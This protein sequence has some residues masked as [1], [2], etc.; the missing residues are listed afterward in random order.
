[1]G[2]LGLFCAGALLLCAACQ[3]GQAP[4]A[5]YGLA[6]EVVCRVNTEAISKGQVEER[7]PEIMDKLLAWR[8]A[9]EAAGEWN[10]EAQKK[11]DDL[12]IPPFRDALRRVVRDRMLLQHAK[13]DP[14]FRLEERIVEKRLNETMARLKSQGLVGAQG[15]SRGEVEKRV[16]EQV[17]IDTYR[18]S[19]F[20]SFVDDPRKPDVEKYYRENT[21]R[22]QRPAGVKVRIVR[23]DMR[24]PN[25][26][27]GKTEPQDARA[28]AQRLRDDV[29]LY[30]ANFIEVARNS[31]NDEESRARGG[32]I[33]LNPTDPYLNPE[34]YNQELARAIRGLQPGK[35][36]EVFALGASSFAFVLVEDRREAGPIPLE[37]ELFEQI[38]NTLREQKTRKQEDEWFR[39]ALAKS[40]VLH[41]VEGVA[42]P[43][44]V[45]FFFE[46]DEAPTE[47]P[48]EKAE[49][50][51]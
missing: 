1:V 10:A 7:M 13:A 31:S 20:S 17:T 40:L 33:L 47:G 27:T 48:A 19:T 46:K 11:Y 14:N 8:R 32:L 35:V 29:V 39:K 34:A 43:L 18:W 38:Y 2:P 12:Y 15:F 50:S 25:K 6:Q 30:G 22:F 28:V 5:S 45:E 24:V 4:P 42:K 26:V 41:V 49:K 44:P 37:G 23:L 16:R 51:K 9:L 36:S 21:A 3:A